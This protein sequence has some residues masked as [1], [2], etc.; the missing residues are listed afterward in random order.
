MN[1]RTDGQGHTCTRLKM[2]EICYISYIC[3]HLQILCRCVPALAFLPEEH[4]RDALRELRREMVELCP[5]AAEWIIDWFEKFYVGPDAMFPPDE[6][7]VK[8]IEMQR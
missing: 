6:W 5:E 7:R 8:R 1:G 3:T 4:I 2:L